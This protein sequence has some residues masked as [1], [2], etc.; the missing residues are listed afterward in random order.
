MELPGQPGIL[1]GY[2]NNET[3]YC[4][5]HLGDSKV[6]VTH[7]AAFKEKVFPSLPS[8]IEETLSLSLNFNN[9]SPVSSNDSDMK[10]TRTFKPSETIQETEEKIDN[11]HMENI[12]KE[13]PAQLP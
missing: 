11:N 8:T 7:Y 6:A 1:I 4:T 3:S 10:A 12:N 9:A 5:F 13:L 2:D